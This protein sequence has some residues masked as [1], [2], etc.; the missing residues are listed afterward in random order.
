MAD[1]MPGQMYCASMRFLIYTT[2]E[3]DGRDLSILLSSKTPFMFLEYVY[4]QASTRYLRL[5]TPAG[6]RYAAPGATVKFN[7]WGS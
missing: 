7:P 4:N 3:P 2:L 5:V 1:L 6:I